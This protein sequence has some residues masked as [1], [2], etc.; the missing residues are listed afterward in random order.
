MRENGSWLGFLFQPAKAP[1]L[2]PSQNQTAQFHGGYQSSISVSCKTT[3][4]N[5]NKINLAFFLP[6]PQP[7]KKPKKFNNS[8][9]SLNNYASKTIL[10]FWVRQVFN[11]FSVAKLLKLQGCIP[12]PIPTHP[13][14]SLVCVQNGERL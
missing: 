13:P 9:L 3:K 7:T 1:I 12:T 8:P 5:N 11:F 4:N 2:K 10:S 14:N 6:P